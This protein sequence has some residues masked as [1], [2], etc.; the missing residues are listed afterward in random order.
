MAV[1]KGLLMIEKNRGPFA[2]I[3]SKSVFM[4]MQWSGKRGDEEKREIEKWSG[5]APS[6]LLHYDVARSQAPPL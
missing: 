4:I 6:H 3:S 5:E 1:E 2:S